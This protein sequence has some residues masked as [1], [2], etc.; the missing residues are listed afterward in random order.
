M[1]GLKV[2]GIDRV[3]LINDLTAI[4][5][6]ELKVNM[7]S[8]TVETDSGLFDGEIK[9]YINDTKHLDK[10]IKKLEKVDGVAKVSRFEPHGNNGQIS[11]SGPV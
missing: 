6:D 1:S 3:G 4:I 2:V 11:P 8:I 5:S 9:L 7:K 10:L